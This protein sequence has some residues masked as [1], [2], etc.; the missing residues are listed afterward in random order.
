MERATERLLDAAF[1][2]LDRHLVSGEASPG[3]DEFVAAAPVL[4]GSYPWRV[5]FF[6]RHLKEWDVGYGPMRVPCPG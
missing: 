3:A 6:R 1:K 5:R 2:E 4:L